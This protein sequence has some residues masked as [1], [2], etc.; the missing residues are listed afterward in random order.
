MVEV[1]MN[2]LTSK[3]N[4]LSIVPRRL[5]N[6][7]RGNPDAF[8]KN[9]KGVIHVGANLGQERDIYAAK[10]LNVVW[11]EPI[12]EIFERLTK[13]IAPFPKQKAFCRLITDVDDREY[14]LN[15]S[16]H[17]GRS[18]SIFELAEHRK[19]WPDTSFTGKITVKSIR[20][21][22]LVRRES[23]ELSTYDTLVMD[24]QGSELLVLQ[25]AID[26]LSRFRFIKTEVADFESY[27]SCCQFPE[28]NEFLV[29]QG[30][31]LIAKHEFVRRKGTGSYF[32]VLYEA[33][34]QFV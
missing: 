23:I 3:K 11:I 2:P 17:D 15:L 25:G 34:S 26:S 19:L 32:D 7:V 28:I 13:L 10:D 4:L 21:S 24:T 29:Q 14:S 6:L 16:N 30:F 8:L 27:K 1:Y 33:E 18:S 22:T 12:P 5:L 31:R 9:S 20:L